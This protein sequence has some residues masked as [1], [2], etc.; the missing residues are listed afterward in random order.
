MASNNG[1]SGFAAG[2]LLGSVVGAAVAL[3]FA[4]Q[5]GSD[6]RAQISATSAVNPLRREPQPGSGYFGDE[7]VADAY[8]PPRIVLDEGRSD[9]AM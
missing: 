7:P 4:P 1:S 2:F 6:T 8:E 3:L 5:S 9:S